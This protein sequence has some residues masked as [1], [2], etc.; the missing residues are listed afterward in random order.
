[1]HGPNFW[2]N[3]EE[4][5]YWIDYNGTDADADGIGDTAYVLNLCDGNGNPLTDGPTVQDRFPL[6]VPF[7][8]D[9]VTIELPEWALSPTP[10]TSPSPTQSSEPQQLEQFPA[11]WV[12]AVAV[13][14]AVVSIILLVYFKKHR[15]QTEK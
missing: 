8:I 10:S 12:A 13:P 2:D 1:V 14:A 3:G 6:M 9:S 15:R 7:D 5:N 11:T 4:G